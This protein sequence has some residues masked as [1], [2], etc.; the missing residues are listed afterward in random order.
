[1][2]AITFRNSAVM[3]PCIANT[4]VTSPFA[5]LTKLSQLLHHGGNEDALVVMHEV[6]SL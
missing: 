6:K 1:M 5:S 3:N 2:N 4:S